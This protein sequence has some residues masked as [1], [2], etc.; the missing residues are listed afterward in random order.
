VLSP[1]LI[2]AFSTGGTGCS[3]TITNVNDVDASFVGVGTGCQDFLDYDGGRIGSAQQVLVVAT[4]AVNAWKPDLEMTGLQG[5]LSPDG[6]DVDGGWTFTFSNPTVSGQATVDPFATHTVVAGDCGYM[7][8]TPVIRDFKID[9][10]LAFA[11]AADAGCVLGS[12]VPV[13]LAGQSDS[14]SPLYGIDP[15]WLINATVAGTSSTCVVNA[16]T[17]AFGIPQDGG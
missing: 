13:R 16:I 17:G 12:V 10:P 11:I 4:A 14:S 8:N 15:A 7:S 5:K 2:V 1:L 3:S 9:S 6:T